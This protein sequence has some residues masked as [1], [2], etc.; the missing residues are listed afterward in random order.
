MIAEA[1]EA[2]MESVWKS[3]SWSDVEEEEEDEGGALLSG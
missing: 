2:A 1:W 3:W